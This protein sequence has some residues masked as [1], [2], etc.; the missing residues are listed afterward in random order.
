MCSTYIDEIN[1]DIN[2]PNCSST[3]C[4]YGNLESWDSDDT[5]KG[6]FYPLHIKNHGWLVLDQPKVDLIE[7]EKFNACYECGHIWSTLS[8][9][10]YKQVID[11]CNWEGGPQIPPKKGKPYFWIFSW[12]IFLSFGAA[13]LFFQLNT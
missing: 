13:I 11:E 12:L 5:F 9:N 6:H 2:C 8:L 3:K 4:L 10:Q 1:M 7:K